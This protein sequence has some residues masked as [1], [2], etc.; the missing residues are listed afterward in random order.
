MSESPKSQCPICDYERFVED[1]VAM[2]IY[3]EHYDE[4]ADAF[5][6]ESR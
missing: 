1:R 5:G 4:I 3:R 6:G 2:H